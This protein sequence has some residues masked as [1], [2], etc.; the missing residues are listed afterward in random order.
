[1]PGTLCRCQRTLSWAGM[2]LRPVPAHGARGHLPAA[3]QLGH[4]IRAPKHHGNSG[5]PRNLS[6]ERAR[7]MHS[8]RFIKFYIVQ[9]L[10]ALAV[11]QP[12]FSV[13]LQQVFQTCSMCTRWLHKPV[14]VPGKSQPH[15][16]LVELCKPLS[17]KCVQFATALLQKS[18]NGKIVCCNIHIHCGNDSFFKS[19]S[20]LP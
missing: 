18:E 17:I 10:V 7:C 6:L 13:D 5:L 8:Q 3:A 20:F 4:G 9:L 12:G 14:I 11:P 1:M 19:L 16:F 15:L 2:V